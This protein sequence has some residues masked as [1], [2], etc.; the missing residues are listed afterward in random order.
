M[1]TP[2]SLV[3]V[4]VCVA[5]AL[6]LYVALGLSWAGARLHDIEPE[7][8]NLSTRKRKLFRKEQ[9]AGAGGAAHA[10]KQK[11]SSYFVPQ[12]PHILNLLEERLPFVYV[13]REVSHYALCYTSTSLSGSL[14]TVYS[15]KSL[16]RSLHT[17]FDCMFY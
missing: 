6:M 13:T 4:H 14:R 16:E 3:M 12:L 9:A 2:V 7:D 1:N 5:T 17:R 8:P 10:K 11:T 15:C